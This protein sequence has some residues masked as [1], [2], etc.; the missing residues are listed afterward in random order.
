VRAADESANC[1]DGASSL[2][3]ALLPSAEGLLRAR[4]VTKQPEPAHDG[5]NRR[6]CQ[7]RVASCDPE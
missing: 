2:S 1:G 3:S 4:A 7:W 6:C 5:A